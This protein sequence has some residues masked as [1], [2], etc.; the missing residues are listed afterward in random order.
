M[1]QEKNHPLRHG[2]MKA[3]NKRRSGIFAELGKIDS[4]V[5][6]NKF[7]EALAE[8]CAIEAV[9]SS[10]VPSEELAFYS[11]LRG[12]VLWRLGEKKLALEGAQK[13]LD[14]YL[15]FQNLKGI[16][17][18][19]NLTGSILI[20]LG[21]L[22]AAEE[23]L[24]LAVSGFKM[25]GDWAQAARALNKVAHLHSVEGKLNL[26]TYFNKQARECASKAKD[27]YYELV[28]CCSRAVYHRLAGEWRLALSNLEKFLAESRKADDF[29]NYVFGLINVGHAHFLKE[30]FKV[31]RKS[32]LEA[33]GVATRE[34]MIGNL[35]IAY[36]FLAE[37]SIAEGRFSEAEDYLKKA[38]EIGERVS[39]YG[40]I[41]TQCWRLMG[42]LHL[43]KKEYDQALKAYETCRSYLIKLPERLEEGAMY[44]GM[45]ICYLHKDQLSLAQNCF[46]KGIEIFEACENNWE[47]A[48]TYVEA[49]EWG[50]FALAEIRPKL[51]WAKGIFRELEHPAWETRVQLLLGRSESL[52]AELPLR[53][54]HE[55]ADRER[56]LKVLEGTEGNISRAADKLGITRQALHY[57]I[58]RYKI[59]L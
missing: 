5:Q 13:A 36:E 25:A 53:L 44:R 7:K 31:A 32:Y 56:I 58:N 15:S 40:T 34:N 6:T 38:M 3:S 35:K 17:K 14:L 54:A 57:K 2:L 4:L 29:F 51:S 30:S 26:A 10:K 46:R 16:G 12:F 43:A 19:Q 23:P 48:K 37:L 39:P 27:W 49:A 45:G 24:L 42:D 20:D 50:V 1:I 22:R 21:N 52:S 28:L 18:S 55:V 33:I 9:L 59:D 47:L 8:L 41:M 11:Y